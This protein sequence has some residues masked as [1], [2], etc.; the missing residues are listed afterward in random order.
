MLARCQCSQS[1]NVLG[2]AK[3]ACEAVLIVHLL[4]LSSW[5]GGR[6][7][8]TLHRVVNASE[9]FST[10]FFLAPNWDAEVL[11]MRSC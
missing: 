7:R 9:R 2:A 5:T 6:F 1:F 10:P 3:Q 4:L 8:S 11:P